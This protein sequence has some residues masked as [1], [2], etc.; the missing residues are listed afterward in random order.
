MKELAI[1]IDEMVLFQFCCEISTFL[2]GFETSCRCEKETLTVLFQ[3]DSVPSVVNL[4]GSKADLNST[5]LAQRLGKNVL[6]HN[7]FNL[8][9]C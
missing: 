5:T 4:I 1:L 6:G 9:P 2:K 7:Q 3:Q 8:T